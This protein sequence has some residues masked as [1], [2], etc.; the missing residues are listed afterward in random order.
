MLVGGRLGLM[1]CSVDDLFPPSAGDDEG[2]CPFLLPAAVAVEF[3]ALETSPAAGTGEVVV[4][5][6]L[7]FDPDPPPLGEMMAEGLL[8]CRL[9]PPP[10]TLPDPLE[11]ITVEGL[12]RLT[13]PPP[14]PPPLLAAMEAGVC[15]V[16]FT[17]PGF[18]C[19]TPETRGS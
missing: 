10:P 17:V 15:C 18:L 12:L 16:D 1:Y 8:Y 4:V 2:V 19:V 7:Y 9:T 14:P 6:G 3:A 13:P 5:V 11:E